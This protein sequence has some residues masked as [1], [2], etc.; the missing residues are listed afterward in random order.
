MRLAILK[1]VVKFVQQYEL[2]T[3]FCGTELYITGN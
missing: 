3:A 1:V 2:Y